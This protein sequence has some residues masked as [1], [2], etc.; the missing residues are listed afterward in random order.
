MSAQSKSLEDAAPSSGMPMNMLGMYLFI[1]SEAILFG[2]LLFIF[3]WIKASQT[4]SWP[5]PGQPRLPVVLTGVNTVILLFSGFTMYQ[6]WKMVRQDRKKA[7]TNWLMATCILGVVFLA[8]Q[9]FEWIR[10]IRFGLGVAG[11]LYGGLFYIIIGLH[12]LHVFITVLVMLYVWVRSTTG[13]YT[14]ERHA[15]VTL[16]AMFWLFVVLI[17]PVLYGLVY[18]A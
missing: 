8:V 6:A 3:F 15:G 11:S 1:A 10:L 7:L 16:C 17:W 9:G 5:P 13:V 4:G 18:L 2:V 12:A 14:A